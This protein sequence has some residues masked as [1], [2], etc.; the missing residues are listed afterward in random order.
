MPVEV[1]A[2]SLFSQDPASVAAGKVPQRREI[3]AADLFAP[4]GFADSGGMARDAVSGFVKHEGKTAVGIVEL[5]H[6]MFDAAGQ[7]RGTATDIDALKAALTDPTAYDEVQAGLEPKNTAEKVG[8]GLGS[9]AEFLA[10]G[11]V[12]NPAALENLASKVPL[13]KSVLDTA[14]AGVDT[15]AVLSAQEGSLADP[16]D[17]GLGA[18]AGGIGAGI[19]RALKSVGSR[20]FERAPE[21]FAKI[22]GTPTGKY[23]QGKVLDATREMLRAGE[24]PVGNMDEI[25]AALRA[26]SGRLGA[27]FNAHQAGVGQQTEDV[28]PLI[29]ELLDEVNNRSFTGPGGS[30]AYDAAE[31]QRLREMAKELYDMTSAGQTYDIPREALEQ[32]LAAWQKV[33]QTSLDQ[34]GTGRKMTK[35]GADK[36]MEFLNAGDPERAV[37][38]GPYSRSLS[39]KNQFEGEASRAP[40]KQAPGIGEAGAVRASVGGLVGATAG[41]ALGGP[42]GA[43]AGATIGALATPAIVRFL[44]SPFFRSLAARE[45]NRIGRFLMSQNPDNARAAFSAVGLQLAPEGEEQ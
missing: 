7:F 22:G 26:R 36:L 23:R 21:S 2:R 15:A 5:L 45:Q 6:R 1:D 42:V 32:K 38:S 39:L 4:S 34:P 29:K 30:T 12:K 10:A 31:T 19:G 17:I 11:A 41:G 44:R 14:R 37:L 25:V 3:P 13:G 43:G 20:L 16:R 33:Y 27:D 28:L 18:A 24:A 35:L 8:A 9:A 40:F